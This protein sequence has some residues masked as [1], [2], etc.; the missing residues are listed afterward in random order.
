MAEK[1]VAIVE[2]YRKAQVAFIY[3]NSKQ[4]V[5]GKLAFDCGIRK[6]V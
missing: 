1:F 6:E 3:F 5:K 2:N 4:F